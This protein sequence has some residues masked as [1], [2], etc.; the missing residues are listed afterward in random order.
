MKRSVT[1][2]L[3]ALFLLALCVSCGGGGSAAPQEN[4]TAAAPHAMEDAASPQDIGPDGGTGE[5]LEVGAEVYQR[6]DAKLIRKAQ[7]VMQTTDFDQATAALDQLTERCGGYY[8]QVESQGGGYYASGARRWA[9]YTV[10]IPREQYN[11]FMGAVGEA[12]Y[13]A[14]RTESTEDIGE[15]YY[16][17]Q[18]RLK[19]QQT[20]QDRLLSLL[21]KAEK[22]EDIIALEEALTEVQYQIEQYTSSLKSYD[23]LVDYATIQIDL[24]EVAKISETTGELAPL[25]TRLWNAFT[26]GLGDFGT[27]LGNFA[28]WLAYHFTGV[29]ILLAVAGV[30]LLVLRRRLGWSRKKP[31]PPS[32]G[33]NP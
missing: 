16:D 15:T 4:M 21:E 32:D 23:A 29:L 14:R 25:S 22:M 27:G 11:A 7:L 17:I 13:V 5:R 33:K 9:S 18:L 20:K 26:Q 19:T 28:V 2:L 1:L 10:R 3:C 6:E 24:E 30:V 12:G 31:Q 8:E